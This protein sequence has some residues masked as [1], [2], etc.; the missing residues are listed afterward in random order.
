MGKFIK[1]LL[2]MTILLGLLLGVVVIG[3]VLYIDPND[4][5]DRIIA[6]VEEET[7]RKLKLAC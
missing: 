1:L 7:G 3:A 4:H 2:G 5:K 6:K